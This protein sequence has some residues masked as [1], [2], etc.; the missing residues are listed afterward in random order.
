MPSQD[1]L[2]KRLSLKG[3]QY[4]LLDQEA[5]TAFRKEQND[6]LRGNVLREQQT[7]KAQAV[8]D[9]LTEKIVALEAEVVEK[10]SDL[11]DTIMSFSQYNAEVEALEATKVT[12]SFKN[13]KLGEKLADIEALIATKKLEIDSNLEKY[14]KDRRTALNESIREL[15]Q[16]E[17]NAKEE[18]ASINQSMQETQAAIDARMKLAS[19][20]IEQAADTLKGIF[21]ETEEQEERLT[22]LKAQTVALEP[23][24]K[25]ALYKRD[26]AVAITKKAKIEFDQFIDYEQK[27]RKVLNTKDKE[28]QD[29]QSE[30]DASNQFIE[31]RRSFLPPL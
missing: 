21:K 20:E 17:A 29:R 1:E 28:L 4:T 15:E 31:N 23:E 19:D 14:E 25:R 3:K 8:L 10:K 26:E 12:L 24:V 6:W 30:L 5:E 27:A 9:N 7:N 22:K 16:Q 2:P 11:Q 18:L 13:Q